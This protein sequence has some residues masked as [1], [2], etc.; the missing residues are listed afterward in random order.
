VRTGSGTGG[1]HSRDETLINFRGNLAGEGATHFFESW[2]VPQVRKVTALL[3]FDWLNAAGVAFQENAF[4]A[5]LFLQNE[6]SPVARQSGESLN[7][8][9]LRNSVKVREPSDLGIG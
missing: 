5:R 8:I 2:K 9:K 6:A 1:F 4:A 3:R 7:E